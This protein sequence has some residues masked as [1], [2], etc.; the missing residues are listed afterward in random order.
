MPRLTQYVGL[1]KRLRREYIGLDT[2][3]SAAAYGATLLNVSECGCDWNEGPFTHTIFFIRYSRM[4][5]DNR[6]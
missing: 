3:V 1:F 6:L 4:D 5:L 2:D